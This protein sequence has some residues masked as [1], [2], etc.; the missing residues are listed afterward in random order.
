VLSV[1]VPR[2]AG[3]AAGVPSGVAEYFNTATAV[4]GSLDPDPVSS[5][6]R[7]VGPHMSMDAVFIPYRFLVEA[8]IKTTD[9]GSSRLD[10]GV[11]HIVGN[12]MVGRDK[13]DRFS[14]NPRRYHHGRIEDDHFRRA[15]GQDAR[16]TSRNESIAYLLG[17][18][19]PLCGGTGGSTQHPILE[20]RVI[21]KAFSRSGG[22]KFLKAVKEVG[23]V[24][25][26]HVARLYPHPQNDIT[27]HGC[28]L[29]VCGEVK[30]PA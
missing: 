28:T 5:A 26:R 6:I 3:V 23:G 27:T 2:V 19:L 10:R 25:A 17:G 18:T 24:D 13:V 1:V 14:L 9:V 12:R 16:V 4:A 8:A 29:R 11:D 21:E 30:A 20:R 22:G 15:A 7:G